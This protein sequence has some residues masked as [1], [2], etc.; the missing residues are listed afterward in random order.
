MWNNI[1]TTQ[2]ILEITFTLTFSFSNSVVYEGQLYFKMAS[3]FNICVYVLLAIY[4]VL[5]RP[6]SPA[7]QKSE[8]WHDF[9]ETKLPTKVFQSDWYWTFKVYV[10]I[11]THD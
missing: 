11:L 3:I 5:S 7:L 6:V 10:N 4:N 9:S 2:I 8:I 1:R